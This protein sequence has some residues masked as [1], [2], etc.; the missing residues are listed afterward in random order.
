MPTPYD[1]LR[2]NQLEILLAAL[3]HNVFVTNVDENG[4]E[5]LLHPVVKDMEAIIKLS[6]EWDREDLK[7]IIGSLVNVEL[8][9]LR[10]AIEGMRTE[11]D[12]EKFYLTELV[13]YALSH[14]H[15]L[16]RVLA[17]F[18]GNRENHA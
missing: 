3:N 2:E 10:E 9:T 16:D 1:T 18:S 8:S 14:N 13:T 6:G 4:K 11:L 7:E 5:V 12:P 17:L 15:T